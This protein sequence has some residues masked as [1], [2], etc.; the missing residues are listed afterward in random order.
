MAKQSGLGDQLYVAGYDLSGDIGSLG[1]IGGGPAA[2]EVTAVD[3]SGFER[4]GGLRDGRIEFSAFFNKATDR[5]HPRLKLLPTTDA[6]VSYLRG[7]TLGNPGACEVA[8]QINYDGTRGNDG[9]LLLATEALAN[10]FGIE[11]GR[12]LTAG[13]R[14]DGGAVNGTGV[15]FAAASA[16]GLQAYLQ[17]FAFTGTSAT[18]KLQESSNDGAGDAYAD[19]AGAGFTVVSGITAERIQT[20]RSLAVERWLRVVTTGTFSNLIFSV[21]AVRNETEVLF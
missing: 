12:Q 7:T 19:V 2:L 16:F 5:A 10:A 13:K 21:V 18:V 20:S 3:K 17:V 4:I 8:K 11:W 14:T 9:S 6:A 15:D 1:N